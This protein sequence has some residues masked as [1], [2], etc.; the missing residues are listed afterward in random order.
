MTLRSGALVPVLAPGMPP[1]AEFPLLYSYPWD[2]SAGQ[3]SCLGGW[4]AFSGCSYSGSRSIGRSKPITAIRNLIFVLDIGSQMQPI[5]VFQL[6]PSF[7]NSEEG[8]S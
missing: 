4:A 6:A 7:E 2:S 3:P 8:M 1:G 5:R